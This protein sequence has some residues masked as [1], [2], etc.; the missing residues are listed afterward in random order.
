MADRVRAGALRAG[1][2]IVRTLC[3]MLLWW[4]LAGGSAWAFG[5]PVVALAV[6]ASMALQPTR[7]VHIRPLGLLRFLAFFALRSLHAGFDVARRAFSP[8]L[9]IA[10]AIVDHRLRLPVGPT[11]VFLADTMSL[12]PG[13]LSTALDGDRLRLHVLDTGL[14]HEQELRTAEAAV[15]ALFNEVLNDVASEC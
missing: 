12:L 7:R 4:V 5:L 3:A 10:P 6:G 15:A 2:L 13:T 9:P 14:P 8:G 1:T 11:R